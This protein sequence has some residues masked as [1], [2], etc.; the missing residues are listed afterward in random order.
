M[1]CPYPVDPKTILLRENKEL[2]LKSDYEIKTE[3]NTENYEIVYD[4]LENT[5]YYTLE[6]PK[7]IVEEG[8]PDGFTVGI[9]DF[10][11][12]RLVNQTIFDLD[13]CNK[14]GDCEWTFQ[15][16]EDSNNIALLIY[17]GISGK[18]HN[19]ALKFENIQ[20]FAREPETN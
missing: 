16:P 4:M 15:T 7:I 14:Y 6:I 18:T 17:A 10:K 13:Y 5:K 1:D 11:N 2:L 9:Y 20:L 8:E 19:I 12:Q 3:P